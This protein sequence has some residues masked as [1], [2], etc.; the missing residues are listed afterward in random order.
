MPAKLSN[1]NVRRIDLLEELEERYK[2][3]SKEKEKYDALVKTYNDECD[4]HEGRV[5]QW[6]EEVRQYLLKRWKDLTPDIDYHGRDAYARSW[7]IHRMERWTA[8]LDISYT[9]DELRKVVGDEPERP[10]APTTPHMFHR[11][12]NAYNKPDTPSLYEC[13]YQ[14][15]QVL[16]LSD[17][18][19]VP[20]SMYQSVLEVL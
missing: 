3:M 4:K 1:I 16:R 8:S 20:A 10:E 11:K 13:V 12:F 7:Q 9:V 6:R 14:A 18:E 17:D 2:S 5:E 19:Y 15:I